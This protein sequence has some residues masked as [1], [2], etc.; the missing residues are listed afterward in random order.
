LFAVPSFDKAPIFATIVPL[1]LSA[2][3]KPDGH[4]PPLAVEVSAELQP[5][6][7][8]EVAHPHVAGM[9]AI[10]GGAN[11]DAVYR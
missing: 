7:A 2:T 3:E 1:L 9:R 6:G 5:V 4:P 10:P 8:E 11:R